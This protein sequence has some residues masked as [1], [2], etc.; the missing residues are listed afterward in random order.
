MS[1]AN[2]QNT[3]IPADLQPYYDNQQ[4]GGRSWARWLTRILAVIILAVLI[5][6]A[7]RWIWHQT[8]KDTDKKPAT[9]TSQS[10]KSKTS[11]SSAGKSTSGTNSP[12]DLGGSDEGEGTGSGATGTS[13]TP[14]TGSSSSNSNSP[15]STSTSGSA[16]N[17][18]G[19]T[20]SAT[21]TAGDSAALANTGPGETLAIFVAASL[22]FAFVY[23]LRLRQQLR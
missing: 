5:F 12:S 7:V 11:D 22:F 16:A 9:S 19:S 23:E 2:R 14:S 3:T 18:T 15:S 13:S 4:N 1:A 8:H 17:S 21:S 10:T 20:G 6:F